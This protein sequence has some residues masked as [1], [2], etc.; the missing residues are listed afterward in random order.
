MLTLQKLI[1][2][3]LMLNRKIFFLLLTIL[4]IS[5]NK[6]PNRLEESLHFVEENR[7]E[8]EK[9]LNYLKIDLKDSLKYRSAVFLIENMPYY[10]ALHSECLANCTNLYSTFEEYQCTSERAFEILESKYGKR[11]P[12]KYKKVYDSHVITSEVYL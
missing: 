1:L 2:Q 9:V 3:I 5:C 12:N 10:Y 6:F 4:M 11:I 8:L 7:S